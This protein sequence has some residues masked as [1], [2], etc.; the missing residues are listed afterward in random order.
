MMT[1]RNAYDV[2]V[3]DKANRGLAVRIRELACNADITEAL[4][5]ELGITVQA[6]NAYKQG[7]IYPKIENIIKI[8]EF[9]CVSVEY[10]LGLTD[11]PNR[12]INLQSIHEKTGLSVDA[13]CKLNRFCESEKTAR[14]PA[15]ISRIIENTNTEF[16]LSIIIALIDCYESGTEKEL[17]SLDIGGVKEEM[18]RETHIKSMLQL[19]LFEFINDFAESKGDK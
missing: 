8:S 16:F 6:M 12:D 9:F 14:F 19:K 4:R 5:N 7:T 11:I 2:H 3:A 17:V 10:L 1:K 18:F 13:I 15:I